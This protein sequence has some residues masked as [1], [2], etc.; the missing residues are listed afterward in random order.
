MITIKVEGPEPGN[1]TSMISK[2]CF[3]SGFYVQSFSLKNADYVKFDK[4]FISSK[5]EE[6]SDFLILADSKGLD[7]ALRYAKEK[8]VA[9]VRSVEKPA[10]AV[11]KKRGI[12]IYAVNPESAPS[13]RTAD[14]Y[15]M[16][17]LA[18]ICVRITGKAARSA[19]GMDRDSHSSFEEGF[20]NVR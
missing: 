18:K 8:S 19:I 10:S 5:Q 9:I 2:A 6:F 14:A 13:A 1:L 20:R 4:K 15:M 11:A 3:H 12:K 7:N 17:A 16:G